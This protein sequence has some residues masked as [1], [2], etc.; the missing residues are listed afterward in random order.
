MKEVQLEGLS[1]HLRSTTMTMKMSHFELMLIRWPSLSSSKQTIREKL[2]IFS[3]LLELYQ[4]N[5]LPMK[6]RSRMKLRTTV[7]GAI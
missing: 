2:R 7:N 5:Q 1:K 6:K 3:T 4:D